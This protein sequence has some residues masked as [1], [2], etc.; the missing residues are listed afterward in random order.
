MNPIQCFLSVL[1]IS[2]KANDYLC[3]C[4]ENGEMNNI[5]RWFARA[6]EE[7]RLQSATFMATPLVRHLLPQNRFTF[8]SDSS[9]FEIFDFSKTLAQFNASIEFF[10]AASFEQHHGWCCKQTNNEQNYVHFD[11]KNRCRKISAEKAYYL[12]HPIVP[13]ISSIQPGS[14]VLQFFKRSP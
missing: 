9:I 14:I 3:V 5:L 2:V 10:P 8:P 11:Q 4:G 1:I 6:T 13:F 12:K 7:A